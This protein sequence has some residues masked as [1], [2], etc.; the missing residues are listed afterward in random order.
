MN[1]K[2]CFY[3]LL[4]SL[5]LSLAGGSPAVFADA[6]TDAIADQYNRNKSKSKYKVVCRKEAPIGSRIK[7]KVCRTVA[8]IDRSQNQARKAMN[9]LRT[10]VSKNPGG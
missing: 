5:C 7:R 1:I 10:S 9:S 6:E 3:L 2:K 8:S 4:F